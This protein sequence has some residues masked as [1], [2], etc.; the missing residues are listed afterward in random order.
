ASARSASAASAT[1]RSASAAS[2]TAC[3]ASSA[4]TRS[5]SATTAYSTSSAT[6]ACSASATGVGDWS[7]INWSA[8]RDRTRDAGGWGSG[9]TRGLSAALYHVP[10][11]GAEVAWTGERFRDRLGFAAFRHLRDEQEALLLLIEAEC[12]SGLAGGEAASQ[13][14]GCDGRF[15]RGRERSDNWLAKLL[16]RRVEEFD[17]TV[18]FELCCPERGVL[19]VEGGVDLMLRIDGRMAR[20]VARMERHIADLASALDPANG[21]V[22]MP[23]LADH[24]DIAIIAVEPGAGVTYGPEVGRGVESEVKVHDAYRAGESIAQ[25]EIA[26]SVGST[27]EVGHCWKVGN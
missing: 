21:R 26:D 1:A 11:L 10:A 24:P 14:V 4:T 3:S 25:V 19:L 5:S 15:L 8:G 9:G 23:L 7:A 27:R 13:R 22:M 20:G 2:A 18:G 6:T 17:L 12:E 16:E